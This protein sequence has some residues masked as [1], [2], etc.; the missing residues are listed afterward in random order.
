LRGLRVALYNPIPTTKRGRV[1]ARPRF[2]MRGRIRDI[3]VHYIRR[4]EE[5]NNRGYALCGV[6]GQLEKLADDEKVTCQECRDH[7]FQFLRKATNEL[8]GE[9]GKT[10]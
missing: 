3:L 8:S 7:I 5:D 9:T 1:Q 10:D 4:I 6:A 2:T